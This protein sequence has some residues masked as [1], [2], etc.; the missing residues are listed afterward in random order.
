MVINQGTRKCQN[1][2]ILTSN[3]KNNNEICSCKINLYD[4]IIDLTK[5][6]SSNEKNTILEKKKKDYIKPDND[7]SVEIKN[8]PISKKNQTG[9]TKKT[10]KTNNNARN[11][12]DGTCHTSNVSYVMKRTINRIKN[13]SNNHQNILKNNGFKTKFFNKIYN[14]EEVYKMNLDYDSSLSNIQKK[15]NE[16]TKMLYFKY[17]K[18]LF[19]VDEKDIEHFCFKKFDNDLS[20][21]YCKPCKKFLKL[22]ISHGMKYKGKLIN[23]NFINPEIQNITFTYKCNKHHMFHISLFHIAHNLWCPNDYCL[24]ECRNKSVKN[25]SSEFF[26]LKELDTM[27]KQKNIFLQ[28]K[29]Y[30]LFNSHGAIPDTKKNE[31]S[32]YSGD[33][34]RIIRNANNPWEVLQ[35]SKYFQNST[36]TKEEIKKIAK[37]NYYSLALKVHPDKNKNNNAPLAMNI[38]TN[39]MKTIMS[40]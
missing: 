13:V 38:L 2:E 28:A 22:I 37:K 26:R 8:V 1:N 20:T 16:K 4:N 30:C 31:Q 23:L 18:C 15:E 6:E 21:N 39:S 19:C 35:I 34:D 29:I 3:K 27:E 12:C 36:S 32:S 14:A 7:N 9:L 11:T 24:F 17:Y 40:I 33:V 10:N 25:Y 5:V